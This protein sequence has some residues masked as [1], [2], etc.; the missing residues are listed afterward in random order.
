VLLVG[1]QGLTLAMFTRMLGWDKQ[2]VDVLVAN[3]RQAI[4]DP[5]INVYIK[6]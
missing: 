1:A 5:S 2:E 4:Q 6:L 3:I